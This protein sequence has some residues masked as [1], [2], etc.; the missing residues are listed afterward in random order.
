M[1]N[2]NTKHGMYGTT[3][4]RVWLRMK[5]RCYNPKDPAYKW[6][7]ARGLTV[8]ED[9]NSFANFFK[10]MGNKLDPKLTL[11]R[12]DNN[13]GYSKEN[14]CWAYMKEQGNNRR[15]NINLTFNGVTQNISAWA[16]SLGIS[17][18]SLRKR[19]KKWTLQEALTRQKR[20]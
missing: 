15:G 9:W 17:H 5:Q 10:D 8:S 11:E 2:P 20:V 6:Y 16:K 14:C 3:I 12:I 18:E 13:K 1:N 4:Y 7:G 19:L